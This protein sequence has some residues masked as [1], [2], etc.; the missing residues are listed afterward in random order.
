MAFLE[1]PRFPTSISYGSSGGPG[2]NT[3]VIEIKSGYEKRNINWTY[4]R[5][6][7]DASFGIRT[8]ADLEELIAFFHVARG[9]GYGF[10][11][12]DFLDYKSCCIASDISN[13]DQ[14]IAL[15]TA[16]QV[17][18]QLIKTYTKGAIDRERL[19]N[20]P[21]LSTTIAAQAGNAASIATVNIT[22]GVMTLATAHGAGVTITAGYEFDVPVRFDSDKLSVILSMYEGGGT[23]VPLIE[24]K[25]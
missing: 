22:T 2:Y 21:V 18:F 23:S 25:Q 3:D 13:L 8:M 1:T 4:P 12:K 20:K 14:V 15:A 9:R 11:Y 17:D 10:R 16:T 6:G 5:H 24:I 7:Y 19:I